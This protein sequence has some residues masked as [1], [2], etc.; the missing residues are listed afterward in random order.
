MFYLII[1]ILKVL[2]FSCQNLVTSEDLEI[3]FQKFSDP[4]PVNIA[5]NG[6]DGYVY[7]GSIVGAQNALA[8]ANNR[9]VKQIAIYLIYMIKETW[10]EHSETSICG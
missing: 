2:Q 3:F 1:Y 10:R 9:L 8:V 7:F 5:S 4:A 6:L